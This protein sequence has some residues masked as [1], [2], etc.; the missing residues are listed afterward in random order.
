MLK[1]NDKFRE[2]VARFQSDGDRSIIEIIRDYMRIKFHMLK[3]GIEY[4]EHAMYIALF[5]N[6]LIGGKLRTAKYSRTI[7]DKFDPD[8]LSYFRRGI[9]QGLGIDIYDKPDFG[10]VDENLAEI[11]DYLGP[12]AFAGLLSAIRRCYI[13]EGFAADPAYEEA[14]SDIELS[15]IVP[16]LEYALSC[17]DVTKSEREIVSYVN[18]AFRSEYIRLQMEQNG[19]R[20]LGRRDS[21]GKFKAV[22]VQPQ[23]TKTWR[24]IFGTD[25]VDVDAII[26][27]RA[28][29]RSF[30]ER[31]REIVEGDSDKDN[32]SEYKV[33]EG[34]NYRIK[35]RY[36]AD[37]LGIEESV[38]SRTISRIA[39]K[40]RKKTA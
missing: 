22:Y 6:V 30:L 21:E 35:N 2:Q 15:L 16:A 20:R 13:R 39:A 3:R 5:I 19:T 7:S 11:R 37:K 25:V 18:R 4:P 31:V 17:V 24:I 23:E 28:S 33:T 36:I 32:M 14:V 40:I 9:R 38:F 12:V 29:Q 26:A 1:D 34:G 8:D 27:L 10:N